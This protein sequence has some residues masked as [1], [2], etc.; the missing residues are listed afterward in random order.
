M[1]CHWI[2]MSDS[3]GNQVAA[4]QTPPLP[5]DYG[6]TYIVLLPR[7]PRWMFTYWE[8]QLQTLNVFRK[9]FGAEIIDSAHPILRVF[10]WDG[11]ETN[12]SAHRRY[13][14]AVSLEARSWYIEVPEPGCRWFVELGLMTAD[15]RFVLLARSQ[16][17]DLALGQVSDVMD[18]Q[19]GSLDKELEK[20]IEQ[21]GVERIGH[22][23]LE[24]A[25]MLSHRWQMLSSIS[26]WFSSGALSRVSAPGGAPFQK[27]F[28]LQ[29]G[30]EVIVYGA[31]EP[32]A[33]VTIAGKKVAL[34]PDGTF[35]IRLSLPDGL[36]DLPIEA[37]SED[38]S[39]SRQ[40]RT[41][42]ERRTSL[43]EK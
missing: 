16:R 35:S 23:S 24:M 30:C 43:E 13:D 42:I 41:E 36:I 19:W 20:V 21:S 5:R 11:S 39:Q 7:D 38:G 26:S 31:T 8:V 12:G 4:L 1:P 33:R 2:E 18:T 9:Q 34:G 3:S 32:S 40:V 17:V 37:V 10:E 27:P 29:V 14:L 28:W 25:K 15:G 22:G 6:R